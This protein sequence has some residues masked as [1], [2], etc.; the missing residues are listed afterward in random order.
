MTKHKTTEFKFEKLENIPTLITLAD[1]IYKRVPTLFN[2]KVSKY[3][4]KC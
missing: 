3:G 2:S 4:Q 1:N